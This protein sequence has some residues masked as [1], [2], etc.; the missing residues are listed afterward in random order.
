MSAT[1]AARV[2][3]IYS[4]S[5]AVSSL[6]AGFAAD[7]IGPKPL[8]VFSM[9]TLLATLALA[10]SIDSPYL[11][12][13]YV[14]VMGVSGGSYIVVQST[15]WAYHYGRQGL[16]RVQGPAMTLFVCASAVGPLPLAVFHNLTGTST[17]GM[18]VIMALPV[19]SVAA[20]FFTRPGSEG[21]S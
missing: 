4:A 20:L 15:I 13:V 19:L 1:L 21:Q 18:M 16:A 17:L 6:V 8:L 10:V 2:F 9:A 11:A 7:R 5:S 12:V 3:A 14:G